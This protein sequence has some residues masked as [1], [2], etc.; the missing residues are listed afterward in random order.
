MPPGLCATPV[1]FCFFG[2][3]G[4]GVE[5]PGGYRGEGVAERRYARVVD[6]EGAGGGLLLEGW[7]MVG[8]V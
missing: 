6:E 3:C 2:K 5:V 4:G 8:F 1:L 7:H